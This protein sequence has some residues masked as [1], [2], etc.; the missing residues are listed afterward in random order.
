VTLTDLGK[1]GEKVRADSL[2]GQALNRDLEPAA[3]YF[4]PDNSPP[5]RAFH[6]VQ[7]GFDQLWSVCGPGY[8]TLERGTRKK[9][10]KFLPDNSLHRGGQASIMLARLM[11]R[12]MEQLDGRLTDEDEVRVSRGHHRR[13]YRVVEDFYP[14]EHH[15]LV[16]GP[17]AEFTTLREHIVRPEVKSG[18]E[19]GTEFSQALMRGE[20]PSQDPELVKIQR[21][22]ARDWYINTATVQLTRFLFHLDFAL[23]IEDIVQIAKPLGRDANEVRERQL[24]AWRDGMRSYMEYAELDSAALDA[25]GE[26]PPDY[27][28]QEPVSEPPQ[29][30]PANIPTGP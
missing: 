28:E 9:A 24:A 5:E 27:E 22:Y 23:I 10:R 17:M 13:L 26:T 29:G 1:R 14:L 18:Q 2:K 21:D 3:D 30:P 8:P 6:L 7:C 25:R 20:D 15:S 4:K 11:G 19:N 12:L 16:L